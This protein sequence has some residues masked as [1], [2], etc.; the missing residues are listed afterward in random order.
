MIATGACGDC[1]MSRVGIVVGSLGGS[2]TLI[3]ITK[4]VCVCV[5]GIDLF[6]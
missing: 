3:K 4:G 2:V 1:V 6:V 5:F